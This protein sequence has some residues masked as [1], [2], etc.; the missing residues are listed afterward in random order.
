MS[1][2][3]KELRDAKANQDSEQ[4]TLLQT[5]EK[6]SSALSV[7]EGINLKADFIALNAAIEAAR[8]QSQTENFALVADQ[9]N[10]Q[11][12]RTGE[13]AEKLRLEIKNLQKCAL[14][15]EAVRY[16]DMA[17]DI[18]D[19]VDRNL[20]ER[21][22]DCQAWATFDEVVKYA[23]LVMKKNSRDIAPLNGKGVDHQDPTIAALDL[24]CRQLKSLVD[25]YQVYDDVFVLNTEGVVVAAAN[26]RE[27]IGL[28]Q[29]KEDYFRRTRESKKVTVSEMHRS[30]LTGKFAVSYTA[31]INDENGV[32]LGVISTR[33]NWAFAQEIIDKMPIS[34]GCRAYIIDKEGTVIAS[35]MGRGILKNE[36][37]W[38]TA[39]E[40][41]MEGKSGYTVE[42]ARN[43]RPTAWGF[44]HTR[45]FAAYPG[46]AWSAIVS[47][48][49]ELSQME[50]LIEGIKRDGES[51][52]YASET[53][54]NELVQVA[55]NISEL[56][57]S[58]NLINNETNMLAVNASIQAGVAGAEGESFSVI[59]SE[60]GRLA[61]S[62]EEFVAMVNSLTDNLSKC[63]Q[64]TVAVRLVDAAFD[65]IDKIDRNLFERYCDIQAFGTFSTLVDA[66]ISGKNDIQTQ[67]LLK[68]IHAI[69]EV[70][71][72]IFLLDAKGNIISS[73]IRSDLIGQSQADRDWFR[74]CLRGNVVV[75]DLYQSKTVSNYTVT[76][77]MPLRDANNQVCGVVTTRFNC[78]FIYGIL[79]A[80]IVGSECEVSLINSKG[81]L[82][83][84][85]LNTESVLE[86][87]VANFRSFKSMRA[88][89]SGFLTEV[90]KDTNTEYAIGYAQTPGYNN[91][92]GKG[93]GVMVMRTLRKGITGTVV[94]LVKEVEEPKAE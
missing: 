7:L 36:L 34:D 70:Y 32:F 8:S 89:E 19:K 12:Q 6:M 35:T 58:I 2:A 27:F 71:H 37:A 72:D 11:A 66:A 43:G 16:A 81:T 22:C 77:A 79:S 63:V 31:P 59:A 13:L 18:I 74:E 23:K 88:G 75:T 90:P 42:C 26:R 20:F 85:S 92:K 25:T 15:A 86:R 76:F 28:D 62:S 52:L 60:I 67:E 93:W 55:R 24:C 91:Y 64:N 73:A 49:V 4:P 65:T 39:G 1:A 68:K 14:R 10:R 21:N 29:S 9:V 51:H 57:R 17:S 84:S 40:K 54:N 94:N 38:L 78:Q 41:A 56:V 83:G 53:A 30:R 69:Y 3:V 80:A 61:K 47:D 48:P 5:T 50:F 45:G 33:F 46:K 87:S 82:I 44:C